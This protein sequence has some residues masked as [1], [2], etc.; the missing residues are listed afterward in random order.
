MRTSAIVQ[1]FRE[2]AAK[3]PER[4]ALANSEQQ[5]SYQSLERK[6]AYCAS[7]ISEN[8]KTDVVAMLMPNG[9]AFPE[10]LLGA[11]WA[12]KSVA[13]MPTLAPPPLLKL[14]MM[15]VHADKV[16]TSE[17][18]VPRLMEAGV[19]CWIGDTTGEID[20][21][22]HPEQPMAREGHI[23]LYTSGTTGRPKTVE[24]SEGNILANID[25]CADA[26]GFTDK[27]TMLAILPL[28][29]AYGLTVT[30]LLPLTHGARCV[31]VDRFIPRVV[32][33]LIEKF[34]VTCFIAVPSQ[35]RV[36]TKEPT[37]VDASSL[38]LCIAGGERLPDQ[39]ALEFEE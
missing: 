36:L 6:I 37:E 29:H 31:I 16:V 20:P 3:Y 22:D 2:S 23:M 10:L 30:I 26:E 13:V 24:L 21:K 18:F 35:F 34:K 33:Q 17:E 1:R 15:E 38:W 19:P 12:G 14:M 32:L 7:K 5:I 27:E 25:G 9:L 28:F 11:L 8:V 39:V 4:Y